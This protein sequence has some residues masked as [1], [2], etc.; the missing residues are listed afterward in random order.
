MAAFL[1]QEW[2]DLQCR[3][4]GDLPSRPGATARIQVVVSGTP[5]G[6][7]AY[8]LVV[9]DGR[10]AEAA[11]H[12]DDSAQVTLAQTYDDALAIARGELDLNV[13]YMQGRV[14]AAG[15]IGALMAVM[16]LT[17]SAEYAELL[18]GA[19]ADTDL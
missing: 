14:K 2:L 17:Q 9:E 10:L 6:Q 13:A 16:P 8:T 19:A 15:D 1:S 11:L 4:A 5:D 3:L 7:V 18:A 12:P